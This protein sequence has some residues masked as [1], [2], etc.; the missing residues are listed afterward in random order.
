MSQYVS[1]AKA[2]KI[3]GISGTSLRRWAE[4]GKIEVVLSP[5]G[6]RH[7]NV[8]KYLSQHFKTSKTYLPPPKTIPRTKYAYCRVS[9]VK[10]TDD[11]ER[12][13]AY[14]RSKY[15]DHIIVTDVG[16]GLNYKRKGLWRILESSMRGEVEEVVVSYIDR[17]AR[18]AHELI[19]KILPFNPARLVV[20]NRQD[21]V[22]CEQELAEDRL[23]I[24]HVFSCRINGK[25]RYRQTQQGA[26]AKDRSSIETDTPNTGDFKRL[27][28][29]TEGSIVQ[30]LSKDSIVSG[31]IQLQ[32]AENV[33]ASRQDHLQPLFGILEAV[34]LRI[35]S[36][37]QNAT[38][39]A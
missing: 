6:H 7:Y 18:L 24:V 25:R 8:E 34:S 29:T 12:Q 38:R 32:K 9:S 28:R 15:P 1:G 39:P 37:R 13:V 17:L 23:A 19:E 14:L 31:P 36:C 10:Q 22:F 2:E 16:S 30:P 11:L 26:K 5:G 3:L 27:R 35:P 20:E 21:H 33:D 4:E